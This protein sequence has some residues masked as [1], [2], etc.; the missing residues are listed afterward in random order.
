LAVITAAT[1]V[2]VGVKEGIILAIILSLLLHVR[3]YHL[4]EALD[5]FNHQIKS[6]ND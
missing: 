3:L 6:K 4:E 5:A 1:V 2:F